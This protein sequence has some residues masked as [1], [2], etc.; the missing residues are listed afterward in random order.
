MDGTTSLA[1]GGRDP[2]DA[3]TAGPASVVHFYTADP[4][5]RPLVTSMVG[6]L[7]DATSSTAM[8]CPRPLSG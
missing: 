4:T 8:R 1:E 5:R 7:G 3:D 2:E 6:I